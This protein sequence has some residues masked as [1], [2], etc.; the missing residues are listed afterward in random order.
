MESFLIIFICLIINSLLAA[1]EMAFVTVPP[2]ELRPLAKTGSRK[3]QWILDRRSNPERTLSII[4]IGITLVAL[5]AATVGG[6]EAAIQIRPFLIEKWNLSA[7]MAEILSIVIIVLPLA[8]LNIVLGELTPKSLAL[9]TPLKIVLKGSRWISF[10]DKI[11]SPV[12]TLLEWSTKKILYIFFPQSRF[13]PKP[14]GTTIQIGSLTPTHQR[15]VVN[16]VSIERKQVQ[17]VL[18]LWRD[19]VF[20]KK[21]NSMEEVA[22]VIFA[23]G[24][25]RLPVMESQEVVGI[26]HTKEFLGLREAGGTTWENII[27]PLLKV[28]NTDMVLPV[29]RILQKKHGHMALVVSDQGDHLGIVTMEDIIEAF[30]GDIYDEDDDS[31]I[32]KIFADRIQ[33][34]RRTYRNDDFNLIE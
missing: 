24:H 19:V 20:V 3:A 26:L 6:M 12:V 10:A 16:L 5:L 9:R 22:P 30:L 14:Q 33:T 7:F 4:Q 15:A 32:H 25:T 31:R 21:S 11:F 17:D 8:Y 29:L 1:F 2:G 34:R 13:T 28:K 27:H 18:I 23:S